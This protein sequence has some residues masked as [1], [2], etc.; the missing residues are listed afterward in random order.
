MSCC[1]LLLLLSTDLIVVA[2]PAMVPNPIYEGSPVYETI[3]PKIRPLRPSTRTE[4]HVHLNMENETDE[5]RYLDNP[6]NSTLGRDEV[7]I[8]KGSPDLKTIVFPSNGIS[9][10]GDAQAPAE[11]P[12]TIMSP[13]GRPTTLGPTGQQGNMA[14]DETH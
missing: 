7:P 14:T 2:R 8:G 13:A 6:V 4:P 12:Y 11:D 3:D 9:P 1:C 10:Y 5:S